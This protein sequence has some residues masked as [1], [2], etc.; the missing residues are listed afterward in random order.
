MNA[1]QVERLQWIVLTVLGLVA[2]LALAL[3]LGVPI[4]AVLGAMAGTP[5]ARSRRA[6][7][8]SQGKACTW[9]GRTSRQ[10][11]TAASS[12]DSA[13]ASRTEFGRAEKAVA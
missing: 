12:T 4:F 1:N 10:I 8:P 2:G 5:A 6:A 3:P 13:A 11:A 7:A 9:P